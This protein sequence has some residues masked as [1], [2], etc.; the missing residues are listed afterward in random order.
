MQHKKKLRAKLT[1]PIMHAKKTFESCRKRLELKYT[2]QYPRYLNISSAASSRDLPNSAPARTKG[3]VN[4]LI[5][6]RNPKVFRKDDKS[7]NY[8]K[9]SIY[10][11]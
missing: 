9:L 2:Q 1:L 5:I 4:F 10:L 3:N 6:L 8:Y 7:R 11:H